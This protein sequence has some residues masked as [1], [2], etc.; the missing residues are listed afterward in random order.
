ML[1]FAFNSL[2]CAK[3]TEPS[4]KYQYEVIKGRYNCSFK[5]IRNCALEKRIYKKSFAEVRGAA[6][7]VMSQRG[8]I[9][10]INQSDSDAVIVSGYGQLGTFHNALIAIGIMQYKNRLTEVAAA[11]IDPQSSQCTEV[12][13]DRDELSEKSFESF[14]PSQQ[15][16]ALAFTVGSEFMMQLSTQLYGPLNWHKKFW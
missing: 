2:N 9:L 6:V 4:I 15:R 13:I 11:W 16:Q 10:E 8:V 5:E 1:M 14:D 12:K 3:M 7:Q